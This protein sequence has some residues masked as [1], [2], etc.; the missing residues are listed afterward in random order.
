ML[1]IYLS[2]W[3]SL[4]DSEQT[5]SLL[6]DLLGSLPILGKL[7]WSEGERPLRSVARRLP[8]GLH[9]RRKHLHF[10]LLGE[11]AHQSRDEIKQLPCE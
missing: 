10:A 3:T 5:V 8:K 1:S 11:T 6:F 4:T 7:I 2:A 9:T